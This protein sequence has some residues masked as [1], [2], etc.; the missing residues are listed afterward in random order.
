MCFVSGTVCDLCAHVPNHD[1]G[2]FGGGVSGT[3]EKNLNSSSWLH[4]LHAESDTSHVTEPNTSP[5]VLAARARGGGGGGGGEGGGGGVDGAR[6]DPRCIDGS[7]GVRGGA[8]A[9]A[10][11]QT[12]IRPKGALSLAKVRD[13]GSARVQGCSINVCVCVCVCVCL[14]YMYA[15]IY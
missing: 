1:A 2:F 7:A 5:D 14:Y 11:I 6:E 15:H 3:G 12:Q 4:L 9:G 10:F 8:C 13:V